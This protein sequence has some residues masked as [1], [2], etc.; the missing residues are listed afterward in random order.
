[1]VSQPRGEET[2]ARI[3]E[4]ALSCF[5]RDG[6]ERAGVADICRG[7][8]VSKGAFYHHF[9]SKHAVFASLLESWLSELQEQLQA[10]R[11]RAQDAPQELLGM[12][13]LF[14][15]VF[16]DARGQL[17]LFLEFWSQASRDPQIWAET[18]APY[19]RYRDFFAGFIESGV[20]QGSLAPVNPQRAGQTVLA[21]AIGL[22]MQ[23]LLDPDGAD[24]AAAA[25]ESMGL[26]LA[27]LQQQG[28]R[29][30]QEE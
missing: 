23:G 10:V 9:P 18:V 30:P 21:L 19:R 16:R 2:R 3:L 27:G 20:A 5:A 13:G 11:S 28:Q 26:L 6:Y 12:A 24:W 1:M 15:A 17:P 25:P 29:E 4:A 14:G 22:L 7:A 8:A